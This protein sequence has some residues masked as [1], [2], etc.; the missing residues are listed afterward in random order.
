MMMAEA[1]S[2]EP[3]YLDGCT[4]TPT[5]SMA[6]TMRFKQAGGLGLGLSEYNRDRL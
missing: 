6:R 2:F 4:L 3:V 1:L 5:P